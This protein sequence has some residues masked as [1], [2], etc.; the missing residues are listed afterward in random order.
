M[1][2]IVL[3]RLGWN[4]EE[5]IFLGWLKR[6]GEPV[7]IGEP[8]FSL[9]GD[10]ST[11]EIEAV[12]SGVLRISADCPIEGTVVPVGT[13]LGY[14]TQ[15]GDPVPP[16]RVSR[17]SPATEAPSPISVATSAPV[18]APTKTEATQ[19]QAVTP[20]AR[21]TAREQGVNLREVTGTGRGGRIREKDVLTTA[22]ATAR[23][24]P[25]VHAIPHLRHTIAQRLVHSLHT[26]APVTLTTTA[27]ATNLLK[28]REQFKASASSASVPTITDFFIKLTALALQK[29]PG[30]NARWQDDRIVTLKEINIGVAVD[31][32]A[33]LLVP[34]IGNVPALSLRHIAAQTRSLVEQAR[35]R[36]LTAEQMQGG[37]FT[38]T[39]LGGFGIDA[40]TP[41]INWP[42]CAILGVGAIRK[43]AVV[44][45]DRV[46][47][48]EV[49]TLSLTFDH[50]LVDGAPA[51][52]FLQTLCNAIE[53]P[54]AWLIE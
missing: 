7:K 9:E 37:T 42:E 36:K 47:V 21:R 40:F 6:D 22:S 10:K 32:E 43:Q 20:R 12:E 15:A 28:V 35:A 16:E 34:V 48:R 49:V 26:T 33:G 30:L 3:P 39:N 53:N 24:S 38:I 27:D 51:A 29:H 14:I 11:Q 52:R 41:I 50:R 1:S 46:A 8:L 54:S 45:E 44:V 18:A 31:T 13:L 25:S 19:R 17:P 23:E 4:M 5:G 2:E